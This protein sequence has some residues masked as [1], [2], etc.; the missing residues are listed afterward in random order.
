[1]NTILYKMARVLI[2][3]YSALPFAPWQGSSCRSFSSKFFFLCPRSP[4]IAP[5][6][7]FF[8]FTPSKLPFLQDIHY[9]TH[10]C[11]S[12][13]WPE[14]SESIEQIN[15]LAKLLTF[16]HFHRNLGHTV[17]LLLVQTQNLPHHHQTEAAFT[18]RLPENKSAKRRDGR[19][20]ISNETTAFSC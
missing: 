17:R 15:S 20:G 13:K 6:C 16:Q 2:N 3:L 11:K 1:M 7:P 14:S 10:F 19:R 4:E 12:Q 18:Q 5:L 9:P 8:F